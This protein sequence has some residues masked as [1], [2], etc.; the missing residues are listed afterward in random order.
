M[1]D[2]SLWEYLH[3][4]SPP[5][6]SGSPIPICAVLAVLNHQMTA[7]YCRDLTMPVLQK[8]DL[9]EQLLAM[10]YIPQHLSITPP[11][12]IQS[13]P[14]YSI[15]VLHHPLALVKSLTKVLPFF[16]MF[17]RPKCIFGAKGVA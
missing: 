4:L 5:R 3:C 11:R 10:C 2:I 17:L 6:Q 7:I 8:A 1:G 16:H 9:K 12:Y 15:T 14:T 13:S